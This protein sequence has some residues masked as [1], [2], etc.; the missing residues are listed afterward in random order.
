MSR[1]HPVRR[2]VLVAVLAATSLMS[3]AYAV[4]PP[5]AADTPRAT[6]PATEPDGVPVTAPHIIPRPNS[7][8]APQHAGDRGSGTQYLVV[9]GMLVALGVIVLLVRRESRR[10]RP[11]P[12]AS[13]DQA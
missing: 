1:R 9:A 5:A 10:K 8:E 7:G 3:V 2:A 11:R 13:T 6:T 12:Q 4:A